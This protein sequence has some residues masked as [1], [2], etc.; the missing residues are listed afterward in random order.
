MESQDIHSFIIDIAQSQQ[1]A[2]RSCEHHCQLLCLHLRGAHAL[3]FSPPGLL[4]TRASSAGRASGKKTLLFKKQ[5]N[6][7]EFK[8]RLDCLLFMSFQLLKLF[9]CS[10]VNQVKFFSDKII[11]MVQLLLLNPSLII[12]L[13]I[14]PLFFFCYLNFISCNLQCVAVN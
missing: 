1:S 4:S 6:V 14:F 10:S 11:Q 3:C 8:E 9:T 2:D 12:L 13:F 7:Q 5:M